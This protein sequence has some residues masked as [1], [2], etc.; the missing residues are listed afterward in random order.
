MAINTIKKSAT[1]RKIVSYSLVICWIF[2]GYSPALAQ[3]HITIKN[4]QT[5]TVAEL[6][7]Y[8]GQ[9]VI[10]DNPMYICSLCRLSGYGKWRM[11]R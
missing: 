9:T 2:V 6:K 7:P 11:E 5:W 4:P 8:I 1:M 10:F 3:T